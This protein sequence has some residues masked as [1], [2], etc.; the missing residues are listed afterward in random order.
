MQ[1]RG[2]GLDCVTHYAPTSIELKF[3]CSL[4]EQEKTVPCLHMVDGFVA[5]LQPNY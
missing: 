1:E 4:P 5:D 3:M 2:V